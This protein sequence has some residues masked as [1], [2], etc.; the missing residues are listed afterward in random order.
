L[1]AA[2]QELDVRLR[3]T[4]GKQRS[5]N[6]D[7]ARLSKELAD[8]ERAAAAGEQVGEQ[9]RTK[10]ERALTQA[11]ITAGEPWAERRAGV[12]QAIRDA[13]RAIGDFAAGNLDELLAEQTEDAD[14]AAE[15]V[16]QAAQALVTAAAERQAVE[17]RIASLCALVRTAR[18]G[19]VMRSRARD[20]VRE[21]QRLLAAGGERAPLAAVDPHRPRAGQVGQ[22]VA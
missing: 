7:V 1:V 9:T 12:Q 22:P 16:N 8:L 4:E 13:D 15:A 3:E 19:D 21:A 6:E 17:A 10:A 20:A 18:P 5:A 14:A 11:R 2:R